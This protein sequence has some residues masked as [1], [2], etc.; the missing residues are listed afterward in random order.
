MRFEWDEQKNEV[1]RNKHGLSF[2]VA[3]RVFEDPNVFLFIDRVVGGEE[4]WHPIGFVEDRLLF[5]T[6][7]HTYD[8]GEEGPIVRIISARR[9]T[10]QERKLYAEANL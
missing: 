7:V 4:R 10:R 1:N 3:A 9:A 8:E 6:V 2:E 5:L